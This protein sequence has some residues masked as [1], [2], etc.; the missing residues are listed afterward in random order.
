MFAGFSDFPMSLLNSNY[1]VR[2]GG[3]P[4]NSVAAWV[5]PV[6]WVGAG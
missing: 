4:R 5:E 6:T 2:R 3:T 1:A